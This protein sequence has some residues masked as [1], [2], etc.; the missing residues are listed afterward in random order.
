[1]NV[2]ESTKHFEH[3]LSPEIPNKPNIVFGTYLP[4]TILTNQEIES[5]G[6]LT[7]SGN[8]LTADNIQK[9]TGVAKRYVADPTET[10]LAMGLNAA[11]QALNGRKADAVIVST[12]FPVGFN[13]SQR[14]SEEL[15]L[16]PDFHLDVH[17]ACSGFTL[18]LAHIKE[19]EQ[20]S[21]GKKIL[22]VTTEK[23]SP[24]L[25][26][27]RSAGINTDPS[28]AQTIF[29]DGAIAM[30]FEYGKD[31]RVFSAINQAFPKDVQDFIKMPID[32]TLLKPPF[33][34]IPVPYPKSGKFE[35]DGK[36]VYKLICETVPQLIQETIDE[37]SLD[38]PQTIQM[39]VPHQGSGHMVNG[40]SQRLDKYYVYKDFEEGNFSS[41]SIP[42]ALNVAIKRGEIKKGNIVALA[43]FGAGLFASTV[44][45]R[46]G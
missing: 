35:Q 3:P 16:S 20:K 18:S 23:Y 17:A 43:G 14:I 28:L 6:V 31:I 32:R 34:D 9:R 11:Q 40:I 36:K 1:M 38:S 10:P 46:F 13:V 15:G 12:S 41:A 45:V 39:V 27:L 44:V 37:A 33:V 42:K 8:T 2:V 22:F 30:V 24:H 7:P 5:W 21:L 4:K 19:H 29:S 26:N 25:H